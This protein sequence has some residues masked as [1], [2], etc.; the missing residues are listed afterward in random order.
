M[1]LEGKVAIVTGSGSGI[2][3]ATAARFAE[4]GAAVLVAD[5]DEEAAARTVADVEGAGGRVV[6]QRTDVSQAADA[7][8]MVAAAIDAFGGLDVLVNNAGIERNGS[9][10]SMAEED[11]DAVFDVNLKGGFLC[12]KYAIPRIRE[13]G[14]G[15]VL[16]TAS[17]GGLW[18]S[19]NAAAYSAAKAAVVNLTQTMAL[20]HAR[21]GIRV[22]CVCP[23]G[24]RTPLATALVEELGL[25]EAFEE[26]LRHLV[27]F[28]GRLAEPREIA[29]AFVF[30]ASDE[31][32][33]V[34]GESIVVDGGQHAGL[35][36]PEMLEP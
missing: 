13:R 6:P 30:L 19:T 8:A 16:F 7:E 34:T 23:G 21:H 12:S 22:N 14:G 17:V 27:P 31:A 36:I 20:D 33:F 32:S 26:R 3:A 9:V 18:G 15:S 24:T 28:E 25:M 11:W 10:V 35:F 4:E 1:R 2:G 29:D 5:V